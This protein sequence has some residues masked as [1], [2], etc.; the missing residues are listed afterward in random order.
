MD[1]FTKYIRAQANK[2]TAWIGAIGL[3]LLFFGL[4]GV[5]WGLA[6]ALIVLPEAQFTELFKKWAGK[7]G[8]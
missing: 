8:K 2:T 7:I 3:V 5:L 6:L 1:D 4:H